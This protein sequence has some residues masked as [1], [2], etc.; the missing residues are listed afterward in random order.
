MADVTAKVG[1]QKRQRRSNNKPPDIYR[2]QLKQLRRL[3]RHRGQN[4][5]SDGDRSRRYLQALLD[6]G[7]DGPGAHDIAPWLSGDELEQMIGAADFASP[8]WS[9]RTLGD[10]FEVTL[11]EKLIER[12]GLRNIEAFDAPRWQYQQ[13]FVKRR[14]QRDA[15]R[16]RRNRAQAKQEH[17][18]SMQADTIIMR[19]APSGTPISARDMVEAC[20]QR[21][22]LL[23]NWMTGKG[24]RPISDLAKGILR[25]DIPAYDRGLDRRRRTQRSLEQTLHRDAD[26]LVALGLFIERKIAGPNGGLPRREVRQI[27]EG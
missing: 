19:A 27:A 17:Q 8:G 4:H 18:M 7:L 23:Y 12:L 16:K 11:E 15:E 2:L 5:L 9:A 25:R 24:W 3:L 20:H 14:R 6:I 10:H 26:D 21:Q 1:R 22:R 13:E